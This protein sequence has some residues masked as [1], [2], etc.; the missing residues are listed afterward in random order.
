MAAYKKDL[1][2]SIGPIQ[3]TVNLH[4]VRPSSSG[5]GRKI[6]CPDHLVPLSQQYVCKEDDNHRTFSWGEW[7]YAVETPEGL[8]LMDDEAKPEIEPTNELPLIPVPAQEIRDHTFEGD[9]MYYCQPSSR[10]SALTWTI[11]ARQLKTGKVAFMTRGSLRRGS[12]DKL[13][14]LELFRGYPVLREIAFPDEVK[15]APDASVADDVTVDKPTQKLVSEFIDA[16]MSTWDD[17]DT[18]NTW[19]QQFEAW[20]DSSEIVRTN[21]VEKPATKQGPEDLIA[22]LQAAVEA[23]KKK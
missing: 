19:K 5:S 18:T 8:R 20:V 1:V 2:L 23:S 6:V 13:W 21:D 4:T 9:G 14:K 15:E 12:K 22:E 17:V 3:T 11:L 10:A 16:S 7:A